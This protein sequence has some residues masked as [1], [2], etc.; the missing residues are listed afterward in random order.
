M[1]ILESVLFFFTIYMLKRNRKPK[2]QHKSSQTYPVRV[3]R[4]TQTEEID[5]DSMSC[6]EDTFVFE[7]DDFFFSS[8]VSV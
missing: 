5:T 2:T 7:I 3:S 1:L 8:T 6:S 4:G